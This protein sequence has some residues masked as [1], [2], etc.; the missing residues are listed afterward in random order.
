MIKYR[1]ALMCTL[2]QY[3][4]SLLFGDK[5]HKEY[6]NLVEEKQISHDENDIKILRCLAK[7]GRMSRCGC[8]MPD[9]HERVFPRGTGS[10][11]T[12]QRRKK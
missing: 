8:K 1:Y 3:P 5:S 4:R 6:I 2:R 10:C 7:N 9:N 11:R 12:L